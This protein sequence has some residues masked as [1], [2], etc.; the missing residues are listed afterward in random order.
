MTSNLVQNGSIESAA[1]PPDV[2]SALLDRFDRI[3]VWPHPRSVLWLIGAGYFFSFFDVLTIGVALPKI[4]EHFHVSTGTAAVSI[5]A[6][7][8]GYV[9]GALVIGT[10]ADRFGR[11]TGLYLSRGCFTV[12]SLLSAFSPGMVFLDASRFLTG[13]GIGAEIA[14]VSTYL[15]ELSPGGVRGRMAAKAGLFAMSA[16]IVVPFL[17]RLLLPSFDAGWRILFLVG[18]LGGMVTLALRLRFDLPVTLP[19][20]IA[21]GDLTQAHSAVDEAERRAEQQTGRPLPPPAPRAPSV[22]PTEAG[23][24]SAATLFSAPYRRRVV[25]LVT[26]WFIFYLGDYAWLTLGT[27]LLVGKGFG[28]SQTLGFM[29]V[30]SFGFVGGAF[31]GTRVNDRLERKSTAAIALTVWAATMAGIALFPVAPVIMVLGLVSNT[32]LGLFL[33]LMYAYTT[34]NFPTSCR[35]TGVA[36]TD[37]LGHAGGALAPVLVLVAQAA[38]GFTGAFLAMALTGVLAALLVLTGIRMRPAATQ[39]N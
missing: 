4:A 21:T 25:L 20:M 16:Q 22:R 33:F 26:V 5:T 37:G 11:R 15:G 9:V 14:V 36:L 27:T 31:V 38:G 7:L 13:I 32:A 1:E 18:A 30:A 29:T 24:S 10:L 28:L 8:V 34:E 19:R 3:P 2:G 12:G 6:S 35:S 23:R 17:A 39:S